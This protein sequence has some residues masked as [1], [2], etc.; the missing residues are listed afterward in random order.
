MLFPRAKPSIFLLPFTSSR[1]VWI[2]LVVRDRTP[3]LARLLSPQVCCRLFL[4]S[5]Y[6]GATVCARNI[7]HSASLPLIPSLTLGNCSHHRLTS[8]RRT[9]HTSVKCQ[10]KSPR[11]SF[12]A[13]LLPL[14]HSSML[15]RT[16]SLLSF[17]LYCISLSFSHSPFIISLIFSLSLS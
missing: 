11:L 17:P 15:A 6:S 16:H 7:K 14:A 4:N 5:C 12:L 8:I 3:F 13:L 9:L 1:P 10:P 2:P